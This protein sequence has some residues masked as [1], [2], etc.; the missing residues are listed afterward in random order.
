MSLIY[1]K[2]GKIATIT[3]DRPQALNAM[4]A[5]LGVKLRDAWIDFSKDAD[6]AVLIVKGSGDRAFCVGADIKERNSKDSDPHVTQFGR[7]DFLTPMKGIDLFKPVIG[8][9]NGYCLGGGMELAMVCD[10]RL[11]SDTAVFG[12]P[13][14]KRGIFPGMG[15]TQRLP[16]LM[17]YNLAAEILFT[18]KTF[19]AQEAYR[20]G[21]VNRVVPQ[22]ELIT[23]AH[24]LANVLA[25]MSLQSLRSIK[26][27]LLSSYEMPLR[28]GLR[29]EGLL[30]RIVGETDDAREGMKAFVER[31]DPKFQE[32]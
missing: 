2:E 27:S 15:A 16:R 32:S 8:A 31:R 17:P 14:I 1:E 12:Q 7:T 25:D 26:E 3:L 18:G 24:E 21:F 19:D 5:D 28:Q 20:I 10:I 13:E 22:D 29:V 30:R 6:R 9:I 4:N 11:A 23:C